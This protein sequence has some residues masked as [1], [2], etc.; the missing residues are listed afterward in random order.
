MGCLLRSWYLEHAAYLGALQLLEEVVEVRRLVD[1]E[2]QL[3]QRLGEAPCVCLCVYACQLCVGCVVCVC[4]GCV[5]ARVGT[6]GGRAVE[7]GVGGWLA[8]GLNRT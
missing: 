1:P 5:C 4:V 8:R 6:D 3:V 2:V 7:A